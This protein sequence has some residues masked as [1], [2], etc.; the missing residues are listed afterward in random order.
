M[1]DGKFLR[2]WVYV[3]AFYS[4]S[5]CLYFIA[6][7][8]LITSREISFY[9]VIYSLCIAAD[10]ISD[11]LFD[12]SCFTFIPKETNE[13]KML[14]IVSPKDEC[15]ALLGSGIVTQKFGF[16]NKEYNEARCGPLVKEQTRRTRSKKVFL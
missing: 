5:D 13:S 8:F 10:M 11:E 7:L 6:F 3:L 1:E 16:K 14:H 9:F 15:K 4:S 2:R 12:L